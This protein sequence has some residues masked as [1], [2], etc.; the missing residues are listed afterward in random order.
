[1]AAQSRPQCLPRPVQPR[2]DCGHGHRQ[3]YGNLPDRQ[4][5]V[6]KQQNT[7]PLVRRQLV[8]QLPD[9]LRRLRF[10]QRPFRQLFRR[11]LCPSV[12]QGAAIG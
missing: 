2:L 1:M 3:R 12:Q 6:I 8:Y 4:F 9:K 7:R 11:F 10:L 5:I